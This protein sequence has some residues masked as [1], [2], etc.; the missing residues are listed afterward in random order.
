MLSNTDQNKKLLLP[1]KA[2]NHK[3][4]KLGSAENI[5]KMTVGPKSQKSQ[6]TQNSNIAGKATHSV[7]DHDIFTSLSLSESSWKHKEK[8]IVAGKRSTAKGLVESC[9]AEADTIMHCI[10]HTTHQ[11][12]LMTHLTEILPSQN[13]E[14]L[15]SFITA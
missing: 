2:S 4:S 11:Y 7:Y 10:F 1:F 12:I 6:T 15:L 9:Q 3:K 14:W 13:I 5:Q 8:L